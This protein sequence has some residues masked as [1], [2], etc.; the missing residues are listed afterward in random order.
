MQF[1]YASGN[2]LLLNFIP[3]PEC[4]CASTAPVLLALLRRR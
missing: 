2:D 1:K 4:A 3:E